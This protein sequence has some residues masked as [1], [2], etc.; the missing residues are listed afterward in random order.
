MKQLGDLRH[1]LIAFLLAL[2]LYTGAYF[3]IEHRRVAR[4]PWSITFEQSSNAPALVIAQPDLRIQTRI[5]FDGLPLSSNQ[6][7]QVIVF[8]QP[9]AVP[10][11]VPFGKC[12]FLDTT[13]LPGTVTLQCFGHELEMIPRVLIIDHREISWT[14]PVVRV[15]SP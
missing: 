9:R 13:F 10:F 7:E 3:F 8:K 1:F 6:P 12:I 15:S 2:V 5:A 4:Q 14:N 11:D